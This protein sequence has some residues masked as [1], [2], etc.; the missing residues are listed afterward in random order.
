MNKY[1]TTAT[2]TRSTSSLKRKKPATH[3]KSDETE[4]PVLKALRSNSKTRTP[5]KTINL[6]DVMPSSSCAKYPNTS[7]KHSS[8]KLDHSPKDKE[9]L[10]EEKSS[11]SNQ[12]YSPKEHSRLKTHSDS[13]QNQLE[14]TKITTNKRE[15]TSQSTS[16]AIQSRSQTTTSHSQETR[17]RSKSLKSPK[18]SPR[19]KTHR[20][21]KV[22]IGSKSKQTATPDTITKNIASTSKKTIDKSTARESEKSHSR[23]TRAS[24]PKK[25]RTSNSTSPNTKG[26]QSAPKPRRAISTLD[27]EVEPIDWTKD[28][29]LKGYLIPD[30]T[31]TKVYQLKV[32]LVGTEVWRRIQVPENYTFWDLH[33]AIQDSFDWLDSH[34]HSFEVLKNPKDPSSTEMIDVGTPPPFEMPC[35]KTIADWGVKIQDYLSLKAPKCVYKY[36]FGDSWE[37]LIELESIVSREIREL[38]P[39]CIEGEKAGLPEDSGSVDS[40]LHIFKVLKNK[41]HKEYKEIKKWLDEN[42]HD[43]DPERFEAKE[44]YFNNPSKALKDRLGHRFK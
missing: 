10:K 40:F 16:N 9:E 11:Q 38:Y 28:L 18:E 39:R 31:Y 30:D 4:N 33:V 6:G 23:E 2:S 3:E 17:T 41:K 14:S 12:Q 20:K 7:N 34:V 43:Y 5:Q 15:P 22:S 29:N 35:D 25:H 24:K 13:H 8:P 32:T 42:Y 27:F 44:V 21:V 37:H 19:G 36:D 26:Q 1:P